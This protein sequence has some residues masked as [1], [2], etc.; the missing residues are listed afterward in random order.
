MPGPVLRGCPGTDVPSLEPGPTR[1]ALWDRDGTL[2][3]DFGFVGSLDRFV[4]RPGAVAALELA[5]H[6]GYR[7]V[8]VTNQSGVG[9]G[10][11]GEEA[12]AE[13]ARRMADEAPIAACFYCPHTDEDR[14]PARK[15]GPG[16]VEAAAA[17]FGMDRAGSFLVGDRERDLVAAR[18]AG[19][20]GFL[21]GSGPLDELLARILSPRPGA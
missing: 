5:H 15:P 18:A 2:N 9:R 12:V 14:C 10:L 16:L 17:C 7:N 19:V 8:V 13:I 1:L 6:S 4:W 21:C 3:E 11:F 20:A